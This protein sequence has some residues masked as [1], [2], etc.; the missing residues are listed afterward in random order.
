VRYVGG[1]LIAGVIFVLVAWGSMG[2][3][4]HVTVAPGCAVLAEVQTGT[5]IRCVE[6]E[7]KSAADAIR[8]TGEALGGALRGLIVPPGVTP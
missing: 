3:A 7:R 8:A 1:F 5:T 4:S 6:I 2:C